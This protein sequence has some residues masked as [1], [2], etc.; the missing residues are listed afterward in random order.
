MFIQLP[1]IHLHICMRSYVFTVSPKVM[2]TVLLLL[3]ASM[4]LGMM[5][6]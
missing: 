5:Q 2:A 3:I 1:A 4:R 6:M